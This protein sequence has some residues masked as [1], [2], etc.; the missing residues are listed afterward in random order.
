MLYWAVSQHIYIKDAIE[1]YSL[2]D[3]EMGLPKTFTVST[4]EEPNSTQGIGSNQA[5]INFNHSATAP[6]RS[7]KPAAVTQTVNMPPMKL[8]IF[9]YPR[10]IKYNTSI[11]IGLAAMNCG[12]ADDMLRY[13]T[14]KNK[15][16]SLTYVQ[17]KFSELSF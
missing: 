13:F 6:G 16:V 4:K 12:H 5:T 8:P 10:M 7:D 2:A 15:E 14:S 17:L 9:T 1:K 3:T 11:P